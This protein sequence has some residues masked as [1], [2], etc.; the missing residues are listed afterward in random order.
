VRIGQALWHG[1]SLIV[2]DLPVFEAIRLGAVPAAVIG[3]D[4]MTEHEIEIS[5][6]APRLIIR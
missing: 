5:F 2:A 4:L 1:A 3:M 6:S